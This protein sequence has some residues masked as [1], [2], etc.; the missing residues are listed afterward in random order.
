MFHDSK[1]AG[2]LLDSDGFRHKADWCWAAA[3]HMGSCQSSCL[4][5]W[6]TICFLAGARR[7]KAGRGR[8]IIDRCRGE[9]WDCL[10]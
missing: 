6:G 7:R 2:G 3:W 9:E 5:A 8:Y 10:D 1:Q 4:A